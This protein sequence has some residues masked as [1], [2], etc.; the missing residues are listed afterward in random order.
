MFFE[1]IEHVI[2]HIKLSPRLSP[3]CTFKF[4]P[5]LPFHKKVMGDERNIFS[6]LSLIKEYSRSTFFYLSFT[7]SMKLVDAAI[8]NINFLSCLPSYVWRVTTN[9]N[10][11]RKETQQRNENVSTMPRIGKNTCNY[12]RNESY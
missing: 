7:T 4:T 9:L 1:N 2:E 10:F 6:Y 5:L 11:E 8:K 12:K 3:L